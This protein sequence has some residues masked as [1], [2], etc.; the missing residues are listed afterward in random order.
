[1]MSHFATVQFIILS[2][3]LAVKCIREEFPKKWLVA[4]CKALTVVHQCFNRMSL[5]LRNFSLSVF[6]NNRIARFSSTVF[7]LS[8][9]ILCV[10]LLLHMS[11]ESYDLPARGIPLNEERSCRF[12][13]T[14]NRAP[15]IPYFRKV[16]VRLTVLLHITATEQCLRCRTDTESPEATRSAVLHYHATSR[17]NLRCGLFL[18]A[19]AFGR[20]G[21]KTRYTF[22]TPVSLKRYQDPTEYFSHIAYPFGR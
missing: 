4:G 17:R 1:M 19:K 3:Y 8:T 5:A 6:F 12:L 11:H 2:A 16:S 14:K 9:L 21:I 20:S 10:L 22:S 18:S 7:I 13:P 15:L